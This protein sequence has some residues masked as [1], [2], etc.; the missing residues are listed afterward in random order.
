MGSP[1][2][3]RLAAELLSAG[4]PPRAAGGLDQSSSLVEEILGS[5]VQ[6]GAGSEER[7][8]ALRTICDGMVEH[9]R[10]VVSVAELPLGAAERKAIVELRSRGILQAP[11][12]S[13]GTSAGR[14]RF[15][16]PITFCTITQLHSLLSRKS[17]VLF[18]DFAARR[19]LLAVFYRQSYLFALEELWD[20]DEHHAAFWESALKLEGVTK[21]HGLARILAPVIAARRVETLADLQP[22]L[23]AIGSEPDADSPSH[24]ALL[25]LASGIQDVR[26]RRS[27]AA[28]HWVGV[29]L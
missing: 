25:H 12:T 17:P 23:D 2:Y 4:V 18:C 13:H 9:L 10:M 15:A 21:L 27:F 16:S 3:L 22:L 8:V 20:P 5:P 19:P 11:V 7:Q 24:K 29:R 14:T 6:E 1:F 28:E 26:S